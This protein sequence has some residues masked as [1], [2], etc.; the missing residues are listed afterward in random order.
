MTKKSWGRFVL[1]FGGLWS[2]LG[3]FALAGSCGGK[4]ETPPAVSSGLPVQRVVLYRNG[5]GYFERAGQVA[6]DEVKFAVR[7]SQV[8]DFLASLTVVARDG[9]PVEFVSF[10][11]EREKKKPKDET[12]PPA[13]CWPGCGYPPGAC[14]PPA[15][16][17]EP[18]DETEDDEDTLDVVVRL[19][20]GARTHDVLISYVVE[21][22]IW[23]P[24]YRIVVD[25]KAG[26][27]L[28][29][30]WAVVQ[31][32]S[33]EDWKDVALTVT[34][35][36]P[37]TFRADLA[38]PFVP[39]RPLVTD[40]G[41]VVQAAVSAS[42]SVS[43]ET[44]RML[45]LAQDAD[46]NAAPAEP[47][48]VLAAAT[49]EDESGSFGLADVG[50]IGHTYGTGDG[51][52]FGRGGGGL[53]RGEAAGPGVP[54]ARA[55]DVRLGESSTYG[56]LSK[57]VI[58]RIVRQ[59]AGRIRHCYES[60]LR[61]SPSLGGRLSVRWTIGADGNVQSASVVDNATGNDAVGQCVA[62]VVQRM[63]FPQADGLTA[64]VYPFMLQTAGGGEAA[65]AEQPA[66]PPPPPAGLTATG[67]QASLA[68]LAL[69][70]QEGGITT[71]RS[72]APVTIRED[73]STLVAIFNQRV[74]ASDTLL[75]R[76]D[77]GV[78]AS[79]RHPFR[80]VRFTNQAGVTL[81]RGPVAIFAAE[82]FLGQGVLQPLPAGATTS[83]PYALERGVTVSVEPG[84]G[85]EE[86]RLVKVSRGTLTVQRFSVRKTK[87]VVQNLSGRAG[88]L[89]LQHTRVSG[90][91]LKTLPPGAEEVDAAT[92]I[93][94]LELP[95]QGKAELEI[96]ERT[97][98]EQQVGIL[99]DVGRDAVQLYL[100]GAAVDEAA[101]PALRRAL[102]LRERIGAIEADISR[103]SDE[104]DEVTQAMSEVQ[105]NLYAIDGIRRAGAL[106][107][108][109]TRR[110]SDLE[111]R[112]AELQTKVI[113]LTAQRGELTVELDEVLRDV[114]LEVPP[115]GGAEPVE[116][117]ARP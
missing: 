95:A 24:T 51:V 17:A 76:P 12:P 52:G 37:L 55:P 70:S 114:T 27:A 59:H 2:A 108:R 11:I 86:A 5:V 40:R 25:E 9:K 28:L 64:V 116:G 99:S 87:Y 39:E 22:P 14:V 98:L 66:A 31:N 63:V 1:V 65:G 101:G 56:G 100:A 92:V 50:T 103:F 79:S 110:L 73:S 117:P 89:Y 29:Q 43:E 20:G 23:R 77:A 36:A 15:P 82:S 49:T 46:R 54:A 42:V 80:V 44:R 35:G 33:G 32:T 6:G 96:A 4:A 3:A 97:P 94:P 13:A 34:E 107:E 47:A 61:G 83:I 7:K 111:Q 106:R 104:R 74:D 68:L 38:N 109:L 93:V 105:G 71:Y 10:P 112:Y 53:G 91:E 60:A 115:P 45:A 85:V 88:K 8:A 78:P 62:A 18:E 69:G 84:F 41:E 90:W 67:A 30:G 81:E 48:D 75:Y 72:T 57:E 19:Q 102:E 21:S 26:K 16:R 113:D 58:R